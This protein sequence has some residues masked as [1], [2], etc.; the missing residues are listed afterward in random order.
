MRK[1]ALAMTPSVLLDQ[2]GQT[3]LSNY[4]IKP[5]EIVVTG[6]IVSDCSS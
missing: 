3:P 4:V 1:M 6:A 2:A 5:D